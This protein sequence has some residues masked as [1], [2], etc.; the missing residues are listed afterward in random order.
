MAT[1][2]MASR[3]R[4]RG[5]RP[6]QGLD[7][8]RKNIRGN[9]R[10]RYRHKRAPLRAPPALRSQREATGNTIP[11][12]G[13]TVCGCECPQHPHRRKERRSRTTGPTV[14][15]SEAVSLSDGVLSSD[16]I[17]S[18][19]TDHQQRRKRDPDRRRGE[20]QHDLLTTRRSATA[21][22]RPG[23]A[24]YRVRRRRSSARTTT[25]SCQ[26]T[27]QRKPQTGVLISG[28]DSTSNDLRSNTIGGTTAGLGESQ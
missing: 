22:V 25:T 13:S 23:P 1:P 10:R 4:T 7:L 14:S 21:L 5:N 8:R 3:S 26:N 28:G 12:T 17:V 24:Q 15:R 19:N 20:Q 27:I 18:N 2:R 16:N 11:P 6:R 9:D